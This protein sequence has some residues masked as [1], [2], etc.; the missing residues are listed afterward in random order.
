M[1]KAI[2]C[3]EVFPQAPVPRSIGASDM[4]DGHGVLMFSWRRDCA[5]YVTHLL[6][7]IIC[8]RP[9]NL[10]SIIIHSQSMAPSANKHLNLNHAT[11]DA[12]EVWNRLK[13]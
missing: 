3:Q 1:W 13:S 2:P 11:S 4:M 7:S 10:V 6:C 12:A 9:H 8:V 5:N